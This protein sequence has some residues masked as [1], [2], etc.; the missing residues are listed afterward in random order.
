[1]DVSLIPELRRIVGPDAVGAVLEG[2]VTHV[3]AARGLVDV[4]LGAG[5]LHVSMHDARVGSRL[6][7]QLLARDII[8]ATEP[9]KGL[10]V[11]N[12]LAG[13]IS[14]LVKEEQDDAVLVQLD[15]GG[16]TLLARVTQDAVDALHLQ[17]GVH[18]WALVK[19]VSTRGH[20]FHLGYLGL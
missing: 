5:T 19:A 2:R 4:E 9:P 16:P 12:A 15:I 3:D 13:T 10:S 20:A 1:N 14:T 7:V 6:R 17:P 8:L 11:R 18:A